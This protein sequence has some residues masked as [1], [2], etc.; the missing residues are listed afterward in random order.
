MPIP[1]FPPLDKM[2]ESGAAEGEV[3]TVGK[4]AG[5][6]NVEGVAARSTVVTRTVVAVITARELDG[7]VLTVGK[8]AGIVNVEDVARTNDVTRTVAPVTTAR[9]L[10]GECEEMRRTK[11]F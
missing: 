5:I 10:D 2:E 9:E 6:V 11:N 4:V 1:T 8:V 3:L 7:E